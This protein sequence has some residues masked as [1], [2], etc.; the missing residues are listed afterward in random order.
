MKTQKIYEEE[1]MMQ[2]LKK[3][4]TTFNIPSALSN[5]I[6][7]ASKKLFVILIFL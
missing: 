6:N 7:F 5:D 2:F 1:M 4:K 3:N